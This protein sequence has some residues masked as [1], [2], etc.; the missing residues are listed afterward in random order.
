MRG[1]RNDGNVLG[2]LGC[3][4]PPGRFPTVQNRKAHVHQHDVWIFLLR[5]LDA[6]LSIDG[7]DDIEAA[8][9]ESTRQHV[10]IH[11]VVFD[12]QYS[13]HRLFPRRE[14]NHEAPL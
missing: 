11:F 1:Q 3:L 7:D 6:L 10:P 5:H 4:Q 13:R 12:K 14:S 2:L 9:R 8:T